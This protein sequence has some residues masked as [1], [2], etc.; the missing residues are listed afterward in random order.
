MFVFKI[1][2]TIVVPCH[3]ADNS[4]SLDINTLIKIVSNQCISHCL[5]VH[6]KVYCY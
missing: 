2:P 6:S 1:E 5:V 4:V 3:S